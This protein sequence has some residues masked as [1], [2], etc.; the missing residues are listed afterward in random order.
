[1]EVSLPSHY[2]PEAQALADF[3]TPFNTY[4]PAERPSR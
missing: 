2:A 3:V 1:M 4:D